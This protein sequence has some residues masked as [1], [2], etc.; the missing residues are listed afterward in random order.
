MFASYTSGVHNLLARVLPMVLIKRE[1]SVFNCE[2]REQK[3]WKSLLS[4]NK[5]EKVIFLLRKVLIK[6]EEGEN[7]NP[8][9]IKI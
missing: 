4:K 1:F 2:K 8:N 6:K 5:N 9:R 3:S 7:E